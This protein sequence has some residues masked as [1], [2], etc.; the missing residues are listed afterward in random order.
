M[1]LDRLTARGLYVAI[2][3]VRLALKEIR[4]RGIS[5]LGRNDITRPGAR[6][7]SGVH[8]PPGNGGQTNAISL[9]SELDVDGMA[10]LI[11]GGEVPTRHAGDG[12]G[13]YALD[14]AYG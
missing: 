8:V 7:E 11:C 12:S 4:W 13:R 5:F 6:V 1:V 2:H 3:E 10:I 14:A 9:Y